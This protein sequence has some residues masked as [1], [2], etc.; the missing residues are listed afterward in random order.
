M[1]L[2]AGE[3]IKK[4][5]G[6]SW[7]NYIKEKFFIPL[8]MLNAHTS[9]QELE[10]G[11]DIAYPHLDGK[12]QNLYIDDPHAAY[13]IYA[14]TEELS[15]W[16]RMLL[17][18]GQWR[19]NKV[20]TEE[21]IEKIFEPQMILRI[22]RQMRANKT[23]FRAYGL[24]WFLY[25]YAG[26]KIIEHDGGMPGYISKITLVP[27][28]DLGFI[29]LTNDMT[30][31][32]SALRNILL[33]NFFKISGNH[34]FDTYLKMTQKYE[35]YLDERRQERYKQRTKGTAPSLPLK[36][37]EGVYEDQMYGQA[38]LDMLNGSLTIT[39]L[40]TEKWFI[41]HMEHWHFD[42]FRIKFRDEYLP[43]GFV[44]FQFDTDK[45]ITGFTIDLP[46]PDFHFF[47]LNFK[48]IPTQLIPQD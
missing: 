16:V 38:K 2:L 28:E 12:I 47:N 40:P 1:Y 43:E 35:Q 26:R 20:L 19:T 23:N 10:P 3:I 5:S 33:D 45:T 25:D 37:Y 15:H 44:T 22:S 17:Q 11:M 31:I 41:S 34:W 4:V 30:N 32:P 18:K 24:G 6:L 46:N 9:S 42:T 7:E 48:K 39:L 13:S 29:I 27:D 21:A 8:E 36:S 14:G